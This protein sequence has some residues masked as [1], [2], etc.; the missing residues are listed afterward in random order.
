[1]VERRADEVAQPARDRAGAALAARAGSGE[2]TEV[3]RRI[4]AAEALAYIAG[5]QR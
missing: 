3:Y 1:V 2:L 4:T 5:G